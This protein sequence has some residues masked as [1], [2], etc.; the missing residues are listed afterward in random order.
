MSDAITNCRESN[1][2]LAIESCSGSSFTNVIQIIFGQDILLEGS[3][4]GVYGLMFD[5]AVDLPQTI[6]VTSDINL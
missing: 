5:S 6:K 1:G 4:T 3:T 2:L